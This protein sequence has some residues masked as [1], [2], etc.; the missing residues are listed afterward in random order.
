MKYCSNC[1]NANDDGNKFCGDCG[2]VFVQQEK[3]ESDK[4]EKIIEEHTVYKKKWKFSFTK[5]HIVFLSILGVF[6]IS[7]F[8]VEY[9]H[10]KRV[11]RD[12]ISDGQFFLRDVS[13]DALEGSMNS[14]ENKDTGFLKE[15]IA[16]RGGFYE[17]EDKLDS[18]IRNS[19]FYTNTKDDELNK[20]ATAV[21]K[22]AKTLK[23]KYDRINEKIEVQKR[24]N[25]LYLQVNDH[26]TG[27]L[28]YKTIAINGDR[29][30]Y[31]LPINEN[32]KEYDLNQAKKDYV[33]EKD[34]KK[35][36]QW[37]KAI[38][39]LIINAENQYKAAHGVV[40]S[41]NK[42]KSN[43]TYDEKAAQK[44]SQNTDKE[45]LK[46]QLTD[47]TFIAPK[48]NAEGRLS[49]AELEMSL[50]EY[51]MPKNAK[52]EDYELD[53]SDGLPSDDKIVYALRKD[54]HIGN[55]AVVGYYALDENGYIYKY[56]FVEQKVED[57]PL[58][59]IYIEGVLPDNKDDSTTENEGQTYEGYQKEREEKIKE[60]KKNGTYD[61]KD[62]LKYQ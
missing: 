51:L 38:N 32:L 45:K 19:S 21:N 24:V 53:K 40:Q 42:D 35:L 30:S 49:I 52:H 59:N 60:D 8:M 36:S 17:M 50:K 10:K 46:K 1:G 37:Q 11:S 27:Q 33:E 41:N 7:I 22:D 58:T 6:I 25:L 31:N 23:H 20:Q 61:K 15:Y 3:M 14:Y 16:D 12:T 13:I 57:T 26:T 2:Q 43:D 28:Q 18:I 55:M 62:P 48:S 9:N 56:N 29:V 34:G 4:N 44:S 39:K 47:K 54:N 5:R